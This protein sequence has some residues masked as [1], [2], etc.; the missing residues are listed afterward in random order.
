MMANKH[1]SNMPIYY[2]QGDPQDKSNII[3]QLQFMTQNERLNS[4]RLLQQNQQIP[5]GTTGCQPTLFQ[6]VQNNQDQHQQFYNQQL[7][8]NPN[9]NNQFQQQNN[10]LQSQQQNY[11]PQSQQQSYRPQLLQEQ[12]EDIEEDNLNID[13]DVELEQGTSSD[14]PKNNSKPIIDVITSRLTSNRGVKRG[15]NQQDTNSDATNSPPQITNKKTK[16]FE[17]NVAPI[18]YFRINYDFV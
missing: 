14:T 15:N 7:N 13:W 5:M 3:A 9:M 2:Q 17:N 11:Q 6:N 8:Y 16:A 10:Q 12:N 1:N 4:Q 18:I